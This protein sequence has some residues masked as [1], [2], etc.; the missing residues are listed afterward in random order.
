MQKKYQ[1]LLTFCYKL[2]TVTG[3]EVT[4]NKIPLVSSIYS[5]AKPGYYTNRY[6]RLKNLFDQFENNL[7]MDK[8]T[9][10]ILEYVHAPEL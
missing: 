5:H 10:R 8:Q 9:G 7:Q 2:C 4:P 6:Y 3:G 1:L